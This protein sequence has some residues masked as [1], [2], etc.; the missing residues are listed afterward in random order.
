MTFCVIIL[1]NPVLSRLLNLILL[2]SLK[3]ERAEISHLP[4]LYI[5][6]LSPKIIYYLLFII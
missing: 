5:Y 3:K 1:Y 6:Y 2:S 4:D